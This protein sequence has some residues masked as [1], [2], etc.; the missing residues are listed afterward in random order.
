M[1]E[2]GSWIAKQFE[3][4]DRTVGDLAK[5]MGIDAGTL[6]EIINGSIKRP[7]DA[8]LSAMAKFFGVS[9]DTVR[10]LIS[11]ERLD[12][13]GD[14]K[15]GDGSPGQTASSLRRPTSAMLIHSGGSSVPSVE[16]TVLPDGLVVSKK[17]SFLL[18][19]AAAIDIMQEFSAHQTQLVIDFEH[20]S[21]GGKYSSPDGKAPAAGWITALRYQVGVG[22]VGTVEWNEDARAMIR[23]GQ[24]RYLSP[25]VAVRQSDSRAIAL[26]SAA[27]T[28]KPA[29]S[30]MDVLAAKSHL[31]KEQRIMAGEPMGPAE[32]G[33]ST[34]VTIG[35]I[36]EKLGIESVEG[37]GTDAILD[38]ILSAID[39]LKT[40]DSGEGDGGAEGDA[41]AAEVAN[42][43]RKLL[44]VDEQAG[45]EELRVIINTLKAGADATAELKKEVVALKANA[46]Q[47][48]V[49]DMLRPYMGVVV[50]NDEANKQDYTDVM[51][52]AAENPERCKRFLGQRVATLPP[53]GQTVAP[54]RS[55]VPGSGSEEDKLLANSLKEHDGNE[56]EALIALQTQLVRKLTD[57]GLTKQAAHSRCKERYPVIFG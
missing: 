46:Q 49:D 44:G 31:R 53:E 33:I 37:S 29:I 20:Q 28:N 40:K 16:I 25:V 18:D 48:N 24:Y 5:A 38:S 50:H 2:L 35:R 19:R 12:S 9:V 8:R 14:I 55:D 13:G 4:D 7:P 23:A 15:S 30:G 57:N 22:I 3:N 21:L 17:G 45:G 32:A 54:N 6:S 52:M 43:V 34:D 11:G 27:L 56:K 10:R 26:H 41:K 42:S 39:S 1:T 51:A 36:M 47:R